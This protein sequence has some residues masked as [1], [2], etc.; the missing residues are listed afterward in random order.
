MS[1]YYRTGRGDGYRRRRGGDGYGEG[2]G[3][4]IIGRRYNVR[5]P[6]QHRRRVGRGEG[7]GEGYRR[8][9]GRGDGYGEGEGDGE[10]YRMTRRGRG[11]FA[12]G[13][14]KGEGPLQKAR[15][16][17]KYANMTLSQIRFLL[18]RPARKKS[19]KPNAWMEFLR[20]WRAA[21]PGN[22]NLQEASYDYKAAKAAAKAAA[23]G[24]Y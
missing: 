4:G 10:G 21:H 5:M 23:S 13:W 1:G 17:P 24:Y 20:T 15:I 22:N 14:K 11:V 8:R 3:E 16:D 18:G 6:V 19:S 2:E 7:D 12:G 9:V